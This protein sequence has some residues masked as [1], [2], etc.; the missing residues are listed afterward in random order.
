MTTV[1]TPDMPVTSKKI[2]ASHVIKLKLSPLLSPLFL[3]DVTITEVTAM[4]GVTGTITPG[5]VG[6]AGNA[7]LQVSSAVYSSLAS[8]ISNN[9]SLVLEIWYDDTTL[10]PNDVGIGSTQVLAHVA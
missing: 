5:S 9:S 2:L 1:N 8:F 7:S 10:V 3:G 4:T 6:S